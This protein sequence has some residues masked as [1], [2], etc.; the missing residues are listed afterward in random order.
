MLASILK[1]KIYPPKVIA[2][3]EA[4]A[5]LWAEGRDLGSLTVS[6]ITSRAGIGKGTAYEYF[7]SKEEIIATALEYDLKIQLERLIAIE[8][9]ANSFRDILEKLMDWL[10]DNFQ[11]NSIFTIF[12]RHDPVVKKIM[13]ELP[14]GKCNCDP[15]QGA[16]IVSTM[17]SQALAVGEAE[18][19]IKKQNPYFGIVAVISQLTSFSMYLANPG[20]AEVT[21]DE[22][23]EFAVE[24]IIK[25]L[26]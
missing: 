15:K 3:N 7:S 20:Y 26:N 11:N 12:F 2:M 8:E 25:M 22:A 14:D 5:S 23:R 6:E 21:I 19:V 9:Q 4:V 16:E 13:S 1:E 18:G 24:S 10:K 17:I